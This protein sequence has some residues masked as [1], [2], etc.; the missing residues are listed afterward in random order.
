VII[1]VQ[2]A[3][4]LLVRTCQKSFHHRDTEAAIEGRIEI[5]EVDGFVLDVL[6]KNGEAVAVIETVLLHCGSF[7]ARIA[8]EGNLLVWCGFVLSRRWG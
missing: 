7:P 6:V 4:G 1:A 5:D 8:G 3:C 2:R